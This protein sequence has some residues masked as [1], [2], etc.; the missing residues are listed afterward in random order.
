MVA[1]FDTQKAV[2]RLRGSGVAEE[3]AAAMV[4]MV[5]EV[6]DGLVTKEDLREQLA[7][8]EARLRGEIYRALLFVALVII[9]TMTAIMAALTQL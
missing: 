9:G 5:V 8:M 4:E 1:L 2:E 6:T 7:L 3:Q